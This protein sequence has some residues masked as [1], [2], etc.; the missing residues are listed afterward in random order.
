MPRVSD[1]HRHHRRR[2][3][4]AAAQRCFLREGFHQTSMADILAES[5]LSAG[6]VYG[7]F[8]GKSDLIAAIAEEV[9]GQ[10]TDL[11][12]PIIDQNPPPTVAEVVRECL[13][14]LSEVMFDENDLARLAPQ[15]WAEA[16][17]DPALAEV[18]QG[19]YRI[20]HRLLSRLVVAE[21]GAGRI[22]TGEDPDEVAKVLFGAMLGYLLQ[23]LLVYDVDPAAYAAGVAALSIARS[24]P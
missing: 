21:Q 22:A 14:T 15:V 16:L 12:E 4:M 24:E 19:R 10:I 20:I 8:P 3:I 9:A 23:R 5:G 13:H 2:Q 7:Y 18:V 11:L 17:R 1:A 6:A